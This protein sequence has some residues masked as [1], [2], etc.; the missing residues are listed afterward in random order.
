MRLRI[1]MMV[2]AAV[3][4]AGTSFAGRHDVTVTASR[5]VE[6]CSD[7]NMRMGDRMVVRGEDR[8]NIGGRRLAIRLGDG[9]G[10]PLKVVG[11]DRSGYDVLLCKMAE[12]AGA[13]ASVRLEQRGDEVSVTG[14]ASGDWGGYMIVR[15]PRDADLEIDAS[16]GPVS[17]ANVAGQ[18]LARIANGPLSLK[19]VAGNV[20]VN[21]SNGPISF[22]GSSGDVSIESQ[23]GPVSIRLESTTWEGGE[24]RIS[25]KNGPVTLRVPD[26]YASGIVV[27]RNARTPFSCPSALCGPRPQFTDDDQTRIEIGAGVPRVHLATRNGPISIKEAD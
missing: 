26:G 13:L 12:D 19:Q 9:N 16:N 11:S 21:A 3:M 17:I 14:R 25:A 23:N 6:D 20:Q 24:L 8:L 10:L 4:V 2:C 7:I 22:T 27:E 5:T 18:L 1:L 15:A